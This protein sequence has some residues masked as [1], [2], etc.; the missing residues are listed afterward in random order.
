VRGLYE[1][2]LHTEGYRPQRGEAGSLLFKRQ[3]KTYLIQLDER[4]PRFVHLLLPDL[5][6]VSAAEQQNIWPILNQI[7]AS[8][9]VVKCVLVDCQV[10]VSLEAFLADPSDLAGLLKRG[11]GLMDCAAESLLAQLREE[12]YAKH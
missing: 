5:W 2:Y 9:K 8:L 12:S 7:N 11:F 1:S 10:W 4:D 3:G 6:T